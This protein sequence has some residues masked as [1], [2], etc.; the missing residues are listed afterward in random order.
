MVPNI[1]YHPT[2]L[3]FFFTAVKAAR[4]GEKLIEEKKELAI[5]SKISCVGEETKP[6]R[7][8]GMAETMFPK[9]MNGFLNP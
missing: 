5:K 6:Q 4:K 7:K 1:E 2:I 9:M 3:P 8:I